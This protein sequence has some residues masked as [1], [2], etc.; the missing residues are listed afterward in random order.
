MLPG[1]SESGTKQTLGEV[2]LKVAYKKPE[3]LLSEYTRSI[4]RGGVTLHTQKSL[5]VGT[6]FVFELHNPGLTKPVE[7]LGEVV[8]STPQPGDRYLLTV[9][10]DP[11]QD[12]GGLDTVLQRIFDLQEYEKLR[13]HARIPLNLPASEEETPFAPLFFVRDL[14]RGGVGL[15]VEAPALPTTVKV[16][17]PFLLEME[18]S[19]GT[20]MLHGEVAWTSAG[21]AEVLPSFGVN[22]GTLRQDTVERLEK[23]LT[24]AAMPPPPWRARICFGIDAVMRMP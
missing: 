11:G 15:E 16:G 1:M 13:R 4:G 20:L 22:F 9:K 7:V 12:R 24:L 19:L 2:R 21:G 6:R 3:D 23:L 17:M 14:S 10:Y 18:L 8:R 5:P